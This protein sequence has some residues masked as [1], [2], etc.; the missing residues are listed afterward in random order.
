MSAPR[1]T[2]ERFE[3]GYWIVDAENDEEYAAGAT[4]RAEAE[5]I[6]AEMNAKEEE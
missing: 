6:A 1:Y 3:F 2:V 5:R 4:T